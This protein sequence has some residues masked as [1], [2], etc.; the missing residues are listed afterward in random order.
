MPTKAELKQKAAHIKLKLR[1]GDKVMIIAGK[2]KGQT[3][4]VVA[5]DPEK[6]KA[7]VFQENPEK[8]GEFRPLNVAIKHKKA[9]YQG[10]K[11]AR[12]AMAVPIHISNLM[13][14]DPK[15][16]AP[17]RVGRKKVDDK[18]VRYAKKSGEVVADGV[19]PT[20]E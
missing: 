15:S 9:K 2:D 19:L 8:E 3:G 20:A 13:L 1:K 12:L 11:S 16:G 17:T 10:E 7:L 5:V 6:Q 18:V 14:L 4:L